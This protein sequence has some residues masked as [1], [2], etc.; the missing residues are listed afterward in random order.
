MQIEEWKYYNH[1]A[2]PTTAPHE[3]PD[4]RAIENGDV[5]KIGGVF[6]Y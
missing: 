2:I 4:L 6:L 5:W 1:A 3:M